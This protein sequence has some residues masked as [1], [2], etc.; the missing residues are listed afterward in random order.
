MYGAILLSVTDSKG[1]GL[2]R[3][4]AAYELKCGIDTVLNMSSL[5]AA[6]LILMRN[7]PHDVFLEDRCED[8]SEKGA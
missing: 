7:D 5:M 6:M 1:G 3:R 8:A 2:Q 4:G